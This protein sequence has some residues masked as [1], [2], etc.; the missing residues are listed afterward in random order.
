MT[1]EASSS[2]AM[3]AQRAAFIFAMVKDE[4]DLIEPWLRYHASIVGL[5]HMCLSP[6]THSSSNASPH[7]LD[8][9][10]LRQKPVPP[11]GL[12]DPCADRFHPLFRLVAGL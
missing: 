9:P 3:S 5:D 7:A 11:A 1:Y 12:L 4:A 8:P 2:A 10:A 6:V